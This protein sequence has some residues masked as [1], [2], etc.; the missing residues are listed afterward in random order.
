MKNKLQ[1]FSIISCSLLLIIF[2]SIIAKS[3]DL[4][5]FEDTFEDGWGNWTSSGK[6][7][8][9]PKSFAA[10]EGEHS[11]LLRRGFRQAGRISLTP[12]NAEGY[13][14]IKVSGWAKPVKMKGKDGLSLEMFDGESWILLTSWSMEN[15]FKNKIYTPFSTQFSTEA[16]GS[17]DN[18]RLRLSIKSDHY[19]EKIFLDNLHVSAV[20]EGNPPAP[21]TNLSAVPDVDVIHYSWSPSPGATH[22]EFDYSGDSE[23]RTYDCPYIPPYHYS[24]DACDP[25]SGSGSSSSSSSSSSSG[26]GYCNVVSI[27]YDTFDSPTPPSITTEPRFSLSASTS[28][29]FSRYYHGSVTA[30]NEFGR[31][32]P[33]ELRRVS[34]L[35]GPPAQEPV[36]GL[37]YEDD[38]GNGVIKVS[39]RLPNDRLTGGNEILLGGD[40]R[41]TRLNNV[42][43]L[44]LS[45]LPIDKMLN[46]E[47]QT[48]VGNDP[49]DYPTTSIP[50]TYRPF[51][52]ELYNTEEFDGETS[53]DSGTFWWPVIENATGYRV[54]VKN[55]TAFSNNTEELKDLRIDVGNTTQAE[56]DLSPNQ[57]YEVSMA[58]Y[59]EQGQG[60]YSNILKVNTFPPPS[61]NPIGTPGMSPSPSPSPSPNV[62]E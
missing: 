20:S 13:G 59:N 27:F 5:L 11:V 15:D 24:G 47:V 41:E 60:P 31:S 48:V 3:D 19:F 22:Y 40:F 9:I 17:L 12:F 36:K 10:Y 26:G 52:A 51:N 39:W 49:K 4:L 34:P 37:I 1:S 2:F 30:I 8:L 28:A 42:N 61:Q 50:I 44:H 54:R 43:E 7:Y 23:S 58:A 25:S 35:I 56:I 14:E 32:E 33:V 45:C 18:I 55:L 57:R 62:G 21:V 46:L 53:E 6:A 38:T 16:F 29:R